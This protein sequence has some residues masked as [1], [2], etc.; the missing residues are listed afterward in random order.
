MTE[1]GSQTGAEIL[2]ALIIG[3]GPAGTAAAFRARELGLNALV[4]DYDDILKRIRDYPK[5]KLILPDFGGGDKMAFPDGGECIAA[6]QFGPIDKDDIVERWR[7]LYRTFQIPV[8]IGP[9]IT[10]VSREGDVWVVSTWDHKQGAQQLFRARHVVLALGRGVPRRFDIPG[11]TEGVAYR[12]DDPARYV[13]GPALVVGGGTSAA[14]AVIAISNVKAVQEQ[15]GAVYWSYRGTK[16]PRISKALA[17]R[18]FEAYIGNGNIR[19]FPES[20]PVMVL[21]GPDRNEYVAFRIDRKT[22]PGRPPES[23]HLE[24]LKTQCIAC[25]G[26]DIPEALL[27]SLGIAMV[28]TGAGKKMMAVTPLLETQQKNIYLIGD[29]LSQS[30]LET[31]DFA[32]P[33]E[34]YRQVKHRGN[35]KSSLRDG[36]FVAEVI[37]Q[38]LEGR[39]T[40]EVRIRDAAPAGTRDQRVTTVLALDGG[41]A[42]ASEA[43]EPE[44]EP[45]ELTPYLVLVT[46]DGLEAEE[47][48]VKR[49]G[50]TTLGRVNCDISF[51]NDVL[52]ADS[53]AS[54]SSRGGEYY[55]R[56][57]GSRSGTYLRA[58]PDQPL[59]LR[60]GDLIRAGRQIL[61]IAYDVRGEPPRADHYD[62]AGRH[63]GGYVLQETI[64]FGRSGGP[65]NPDIVLDNADMTLSRFHFAVVNDAGVLRLEDFGSRNG[66]YVKVEAERKLEHGGIFRIG[67]QSFQLRS[68][69][70]LPEKQG[71]EPVPVVEEP[72]ATAVAAPP[73]PP[74]A[75]A[76][77]VP[78]AAGGDAAAPAVAAVAAGPH[79]TFAGQDIGGEIEASSSLLAWADENDVTLDYECWIGMCG[80][81]ALRVVSGAEHLNEVTEKEAKTLKRKGLEPGSCRLACMT[82]TSGPVVVEVVQ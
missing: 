14:E 71:S 2:D 22:Q 56:D 29:L 19:Y 3:G 52:L 5:D 35:I 40:V 65:S 27:S 20:E 53:H 78:V 50:V 11:N 39:P 15:D 12:L 63:V 32:A 77:A 74:P 34:S 30:Y 58:L 68:G 62:M 21:T 46:P 4:V 26:E 67:A 57:D 54:I 37:Q 72:P 36:V 8:R 70:E 82:R 7:D 69:Q 44:L 73:P 10:G 13:E 31:D 55:L 49:E 28:P 79:V 60:H 42:D 48:T 1:N 23:L 64:V 80:A 59:R 16:M 61:V 24:F 43:T 38:R 75:P 47:F 51:P 9:E 33:V 17:D 76:P 41:T 66:T 45:T 25:I 81:D 18:F 6:L